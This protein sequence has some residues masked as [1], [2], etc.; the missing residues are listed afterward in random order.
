MKIVIIGAGPSGL[1]VA[2]RLQQLG[3]DDFV[4]LE[5]EEEPGGLCRSITI[6]GSPLDIGGGH[7]LDVR[8]PKVNE[9]LFEFMPKREWNIFTR[10]SRIELDGCEVTHPIEAN[11]WQM[12][13]DNQI[14]YLISIAKAGCNTGKV[15]PTKFVDWIYWKLG[16]K[17]A[18]SYM[19]PYNRKMFGADL[20][21]L[22]TY[23]LD[24]LPSV[25]FEDTLRSCLEHKAHAKQ[26]GHA[27]FYYPKKYG[28]GELWKRMADSLNGKVIYNEDVCAIDGESH[29]IKTVEGH[30]IYADLIINTAPWKEVRRQA[31]MPEEVVEA[32]DSLKHT[33]VGIQ[34]FNETPETAAQWCYYPNPKVAFHRTLIRK[35][36]IPGAKGYWTETNV[37]AYSAEEQKRY[38]YV[39]D[40]AYPVNMLDKPMQMK[41]ITEWCKGNGILPLG[42]W[43]E[44]THYNSDAVVERALNLAET[45][46]DGLHE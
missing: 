31:S 44:H 34:Y 33:S 45:I 16:I 19:L 15:M 6:D 11:I 27:Q 22:G 10:D 29:K 21:E 35:N 28:Y 17:I 46:I 7:F 40:Y 1:T 39:N 42:R 24:K 4:V 14:E 37:T 38:L 2:N 26:P 3:L 32:I 5:K 41:V 12:G 9:F 25:S 8:R 36:F 30:E 43:G 18:E 23:W 20:E 13:I